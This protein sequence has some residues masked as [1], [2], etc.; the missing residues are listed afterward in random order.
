VGQPGS[1]FTFEVAQKNGIPFSLINK[2]KKKV[3]RGKVRFDESI[4]KL[5][6]ERSKMAKTGDRLQEEESK[7]R[8]EAEKLETLNS[9]LKEKLS[10]YQELYDYHQ[11]MIHLGT[12]V[13]KAAERYF[14]EKKKRPLISELLRIVE[15]ENSK[16]KKPSAESRAEIKKKEQANQ[17]IK[18]EIKEIRSQKAAKKKQ[19]EKRKKS[20]P[21]PVLKVGDRVRLLDGKSVGSIDSIEKDKAIV[22][23]GI[24]TTNVSVDQLELVEKGKKG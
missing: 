11:R 9:K 5:Q 14:R 21:K 4:A 7:A 19:E 3:S 18:K 15:T 24:F 23:Y 1:S 6:K 13:D 20:R 8:E 12:R 17:Q 22:N 2:A 10:S 16:R